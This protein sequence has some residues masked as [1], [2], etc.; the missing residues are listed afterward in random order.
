MT[1]EL[2]NLKIG[3]Q[4]PQLF[5]IPA[6]YTKF[7]MAGMMGGKGMGMPCQK[8]Q[9]TEARPILPIPRV[10]LPRPTTSPMWTKQKT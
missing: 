2:H 3:P 1:T 6:D 10:L 5:E 9:G 8:S 4:D 7:D